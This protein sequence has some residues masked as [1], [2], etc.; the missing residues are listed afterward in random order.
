MTLEERLKKLNITPVR[1]NNERNQLV[2]LG[3]TDEQAKRIIVRKSSKNTVQTLLSVHE[4][5]FIFLKR[6]QIISIAAHD[7]GSKNL[8]AVSTRAK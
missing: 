8:E 2:D 3:Y 4:D 1:F 6:E 5:L 7:G